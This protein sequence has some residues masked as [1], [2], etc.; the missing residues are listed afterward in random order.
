M[1]APLLQVGKL[2][3]TDCNGSLHDDLD[4]SC[5]GRITKTLVLLEWVQPYKHHNT[6][7]TSGTYLYRAEYY[8][9]KFLT[10]EG[11]AGW[12]YFTDAE[13]G[14]RLWLADSKEQKSHG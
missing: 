4:D 8:A 2:Y 3:E 5:S 6:E 13:L 11:D 9:L 12:F 14:V 1:K 10:T 7:R